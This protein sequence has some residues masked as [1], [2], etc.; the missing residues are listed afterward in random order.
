MIVERFYSDPG[1]PFPQYYCNVDHYTRAQSYWLILLRSISGFNEW[2]WSAVIRPVDIRDDQNTGFMFWLRSKESK[3]EI[4]VYTASFEGSVHLYMLDNEGDE[5]EDVSRFEK[6]I[7][8]RS[9]EDDACDLTWSD[10]AQDVRMIYDRFS[11]GVEVGVYFDHDP[12]GL[13]GEVEVPVERLI[14]NSEISEYTEP[15]AIQA[16]ELFLQNGA[17]MERVNRVFLT[18]SKF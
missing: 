18:D 8:C 13:A 15:L 14:I 1:F 6:E 17:A 9:P 7:G 10:A 16:L 12:S 5:D 11:A 2:E 3:K 4:I